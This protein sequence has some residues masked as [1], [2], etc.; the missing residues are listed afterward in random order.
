MFVLQYHG[1][2]LIKTDTDTIMLHKIHTLKEESFA[3]F[4]QIRLF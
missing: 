3:V 2:K 1:E 4:Y